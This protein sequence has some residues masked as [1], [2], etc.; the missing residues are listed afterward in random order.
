VRLKDLA[1]KVGAELYGDGNR[2][3]TGV[4]GIEDAGEG[5]AN[6]ISGVKQHEELNKSGAAAVFVPRREMPAASLPLLRAGNPHE[7]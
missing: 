6:Y 2:E 1:G 7:R 4:A 3:I 5:L